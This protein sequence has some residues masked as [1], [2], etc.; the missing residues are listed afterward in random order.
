M[1]IDY[2]ILF[3]L[4]V[5]EKGKEFCGDAVRDGEP[6]DAFPLNPFL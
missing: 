2:A 4:K 3:F 6:S 5:V 1:L